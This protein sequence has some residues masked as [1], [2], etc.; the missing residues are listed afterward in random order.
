MDTT[1]GGEPLG[2]LGYYSRR[3]Y[4]DYPGLASRRVVDYVRRSGRRDLF[5]MLREIQPHYLVLRESE[6]QNLS[7][8]PDLGA[9]FNRNYAVVRRFA[10]PEE[11]RRRIFLV[12]RNIDV[13]YVLMHRTT[14]RP[15]IV[16]TQRLAAPLTVGEAVIDGG[17]TSRGGFTGSP[18]APSDAQWYGSWSG[19]DANT[20]SVRM[21]LA[22]LEPGRD[23]AVPFLTGPSTN[24]LAIRLVDVDGNAVLAQVDSL[25]VRDRAWAAWRVT[26]PE[27]AR[28]H[29]LALVAEDTGGG[30]GQWLAIAAPRELSR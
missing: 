28:G 2:F 4:Y 10:V 14:P 30:W 25:P 8:H 9:W 22:P 12:E 5:Y 19:D 29:R 27:A 7:T 16:D 6:A 13:A 20:G 18:P 17:W 3:T 24:G 15:E 1:I 26:I 23:I 21:P 11:V